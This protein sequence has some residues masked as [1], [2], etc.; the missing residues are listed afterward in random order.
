MPEWSNLVKAF[1]PLDFLDYT[2]RGCGQVRLATLKLHFSLS[3]WL[4]SGHYQVY[5]MNNPISGI[6]LLIGLVIEKPLLAV[7]CLIGLSVLDV[8]LFILHLTHAGSAGLFS[9]TGFAAQIG[10][11]IGARR[12]GRIKLL[13]PMCPLSVSYVALPGL[14]GYNGILVGAAIV[15]FMKDEWDIPTLL[16]IVPYACISVVRGPYSFMVRIRR[17]TLAIS[18]SGCSWATSWSA[19]GTFHPSRSPST[20]PLSSFLLRAYPSHLAR[21]YERATPCSNSCCPFQFSAIQLLPVG[22][23]H[24]I[25]PHR[26]TAS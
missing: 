4:T 6:I 1:G 17:L 16:I 3:R 10:V 8:Y 25:A 26:G 11:D 9:A 2:L 7:G 24:S 12:A 21:F 18:S 5:F 14:T 19:L 23:V 20:S 15:T 13:V 22:D